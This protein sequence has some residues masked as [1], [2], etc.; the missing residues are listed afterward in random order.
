MALSICGSVREVP[1][2]QLHLMPEPEPMGPRHHPL[3][4]SEMLHLTRL[5]LNANGMDMDNVVP[6]LTEDNKKM[7]CTFD[8]VCKDTGRFLY[9]NVT[10]KMIGALGSFQNQSAR[11]TLAIGQNVFACANETLNAEFVIKHRSTKNLRHN[12]RNMIYDAVPEFDAVFE[13]MTGRQEFLNSVNVTRE[14]ASHHII[15]AGKRG[16][17]NWR[18]IPHVVKYWEEPEH[19]AFKPRNYWSLYNA[20]SGFFQDKNPFDVAD[21]SMRLDSQFDA[22]AQDIQETEADINSWFDTQQTEAEI[23]NDSD[24]MGY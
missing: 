22:I 12:M 16:V 1:L 8:I 21:R 17:I 3:P 24:V 5:G 9:S 13:R 11:Q 19:D 18:E 7:L 23:E 15:E 6:R 4:H 14:V 20:F 2:E 10:M